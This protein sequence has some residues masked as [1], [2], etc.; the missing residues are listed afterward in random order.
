MIK[1]LQ[2]LLR[3]LG[4]WTEQGRPSLLWLLYTSRR[5]D[6]DFARQA[7]RILRGFLM[8]MISNTSR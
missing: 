1:Q 7:A 4:H 8:T 2:A 6:A 3:Y 5:M